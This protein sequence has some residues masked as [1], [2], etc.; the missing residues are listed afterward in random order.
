[1]LQLL[2]SVEENQVPRR[3]PLH[4]LHRAQWG[5]PA[6]PSHRHRQN[7][8]GGLQSAAVSGNAPPSHLET[9]EKTPL[10]QRGMPMLPLTDT[11]KIKRMAYRAQQQQMPPPSPEDQREDAPEA[12]HEQDVVREAGEVRHVQA[13]QIDPALRAPLLPGSENQRRIRKNNVQRECTDVAL[14]RPQPSSLPTPSLSSCPPLAFHLAH[15]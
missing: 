2:T 3:S 15:P 10:T 8:E 9:R 4:S 7:E 1:M 5:M 13:G 12:E 11:D 14:A 6:L